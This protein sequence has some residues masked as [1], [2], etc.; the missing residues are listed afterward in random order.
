MSEPRLILS[1]LAF[2]YDHPLTAPLSL[3]VQAGEI[4]AIVGPSGSGKTTLLATILGSVPALSG[5]ILIDRS[6]VTQAP[7]NRRGI[8][9][10]FQEALLFDHLDVQDNIAYGMRRLGES[11]SAARVRASELLA[12]V[13]LAGFENR[14]VRELSG[15]QA[16]RVALARALAVNPAVL[17]LDEPFSALDFDLRSRLAEDVTI[18]ARQRGCAVLHVTH[19]R[20]E[21][22]RMASTI[23]DLESIA[24]DECRND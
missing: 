1:E 24:I 8:G 19:D 15:G 4:V 20:S 7:I 14:S 22:E 10:V 9:I 2:G 23:V 18:L 5:Q 13:G 11:K 17:L 3:S 21:A 6:N 12:W 16:Q